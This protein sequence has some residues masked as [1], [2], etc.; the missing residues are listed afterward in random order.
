MRRSPKALKK[1]TI[2]FSLVAVFFASSVL[3]LRAAEAV[4]FESVRA[5]ESR[6]MP[7]DAFICYGRSACSGSLQ[8][9][10]YI[11]YV[12]LPEEEQ[13]INAPAVLSLL[14]VG[15]ENGGYSNWWQAS[16][17]LVHTGGT[18]IPIGNAKADDGN[19]YSYT[20]CNPSYN[21]CNPSM[22]WFGVKIPS[23][24]PVGLYTLEVTFTSVVESGVVTSEGFRNVLNVASSAVPAV[25][26]APATTIP[27]VLAPATPSSLLVTKISDFSTNED[28]FIFQRDDVPVA[29][30]TTAINWPYRAAAGATTYDLGGLVPGK[31]Y[32]LTAA[33]YNTGGVS[34][35]AQWACLDL[36]SSS[37]IS[38]GG[39]NPNLTCEGTRQKISGNSV[40]VKIAAGTSNAGRKLIFEA[41]SK[42][43]WSKIGNG[44]VDASGT[45]VI[46][47]KTSIVGKSGKV[48]IRATQGSRFICEGNIS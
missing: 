13:V 48:A 14:S 8:L 3:S 1:F 28:G 34:S 38:S 26:V 35:W 29:V 18:R 44:R 47:S 22:D 36:T 32:C 10:A 42:G 5:P 9:G 27:A 25:T 21:Y 7:K 2:F 20:R 11:R 41:F 45:V 15:I 19:K 31:R 12:Y 39:S 4:Q 17:T 43:K 23:T 40:T 6:L 24:A 33:A 16:G 30:N 37:G 46:T